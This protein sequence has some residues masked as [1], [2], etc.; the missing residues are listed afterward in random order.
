MLM[1]NRYMLS[2]KGT[3]GV[4]WDRTMLMLNFNSVRTGA[5]LSEKWDRTMLMLNYEWWRT[6]SNI[7]QKWDRTMLMLNRSKINILFLHYILYILIFQS[8]IEILPADFSFLPIFFMLDI[9]GFLLFR[10]VNFLNYFNI[11]LNYLHYIIFTYSFI[12]KHIIF[13][14]YRKI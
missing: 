11:F 3:T 13:K 10:L 1:L 12:Y 14:Y 9:V 6:A 8:L 2:I 7:H 4:E 5:M